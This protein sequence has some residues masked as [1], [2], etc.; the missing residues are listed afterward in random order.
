MFS[1]PFSE[2]LVLVVSRKKKFSLFKNT[3]SG[4]FYSEETS[5]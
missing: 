4:K 1:Q 2:F 5:T 3:K